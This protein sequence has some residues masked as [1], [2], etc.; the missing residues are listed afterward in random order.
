MT[1]KAVANT[2]SGGGSG[3]VTAVSVTTA[4]GVSGLVANSTTTPAIT[5]T[6]GAI[7]PS[8]VSTGGQI[9]STLATGTAPLVI[10]ST[11]LVPNLYVA[12]AVLADSATTNANLTG[13]IT[14]VGNATSIASQT[15][16]GT[17]FVV[18]TSPTLITPNIGVATGTSIAIGGAVI[19]SNAM[20][21]TGASTFP[22]VSASLFN[23]VVGAL[24]GN[25]TMTGDVNAIFGWNAGNALI[26]GRENT[27][28]GQSAGRFTTTGSASFPDTGQNTFV[29]S[30]AG[31]TNTTGVG[32]TFVGQKAGTG[33]VTGSTN[34]AIGAHAGAGFLGSS[35]IAVGQFSGSGA[36]TSGVD[37][38]LMGT[39]A[40]NYLQ[41]TAASNILM[42]AFAGA[43][44]VSNPNTA[45]N[46]VFMGYQAGTVNISGSSNLLMGYQAG[47]A[48]TTG[49]GHVFLGYQ[50]GKSNVGGVNNVFIGNGAGANI[51]GTARVILIG[52]N[53]G[54]SLPNS[55]QNYFIAGASGSERIDHVYFGKGYSNTSATGWTL[56]GT[57]GS[58]TDNVGGTVTIIPGLSTGAGTN[59]DLIFQTGIKIASG[60]GFGTAT[61]ALTIKGETQAV[62]AAGTFQSKDLRASKT[63]NYSVLASDTGTQFDNIGA[64]GEVDFTL[65]TAAVGL[66]YGFT[67]KAAQVLKV[68]AGSSTIIAI[69]ASISASAGNIQANTAYSSV[70]L[71]AISTTEWVATSGASG[72]WTVT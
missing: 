53:A 59:P 67:V 51:T 54:D 45:S 13:P 31:Q 62:I 60:T 49:G 38:I 26:A 50:A 21:V 32:N 56:H 25:N 69:G 2:G 30:F 65:P 15:G 55:S 42:G 40:G 8:S 37:N 20:A 16:T 36:S 27:F 18:D 68:I 64:A 52:T 57:N 61:T 23:E 29:G 22:R 1:L 66:K 70:Q 34:T 11:T 28:I 47:V 9:T 24:A 7:T 71:E 35:N 5:L 43:G 72:S 46:N 4:N 33:N 10:T 41:S 3:T 12:R 14:S 39:Q 19:G 44:T 48:N 17:K 63:A 6:L 58:G